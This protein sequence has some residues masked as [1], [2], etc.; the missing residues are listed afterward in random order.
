MFTF[1]YFTIQMVDYLWPVYLRT[2]FPLNSQGIYWLGLIVVVPLLCSFGT[3]IVKL[4]LQSGQRLDREKKLS[5][6]KT[7]FFFIAFGEAVPMLLL[8]SLAHTGRDSPVVFLLIICFC[9]FIAGSPNP[10]FESLVNYYIPDEHARERATIMS[11][12]NMLAGLVVGLLAIPASGPSGEKTAIGWAL[13]AALLLI[14]TV[15]GYFVLKRQETRLPEG[16]LTKV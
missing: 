16:V 13:P 14:T 11:F 15:I 10:V 9:V 7:C 3:Q 6:L 12:S 8:S 2:N 1:S 4:V 5:R